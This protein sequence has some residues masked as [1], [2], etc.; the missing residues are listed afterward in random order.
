VQPDAALVAQLA[1]LARLQVPPERVP[2]LVLEM[3]RILSYVDQLRAAEPEQPRGNQQVFDP[4]LGTCDLQ[5]MAGRLPRRSDE[6]RAG[7]PELIGLSA[8][9]QGAVVAVPP[10]RG[11]DT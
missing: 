3:G 1:G 4:A 7:D 9:R 11:E 8:G 6:P 2:A 10:V 5:A